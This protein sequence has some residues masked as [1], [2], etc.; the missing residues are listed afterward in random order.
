MTGVSKNNGA[1]N[2][3]YVCTFQAGQS[4]V[5]ANWESHNAGQIARTTVVLM[6]EFVNDEAL[7]AGG[8]CCTSHEACK[9]R[10]VSHGSGDDPPRH[11][12]S[13]STRHVMCVTPPGST[14]PR[15]GDTFFR[16]NVSPFG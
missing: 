6:P 12:S 5:L 7:L 2:N 3:E 4:S 13:S 15:L 11:N 9:P 1:K 10:G 16:E 14:S 8:M